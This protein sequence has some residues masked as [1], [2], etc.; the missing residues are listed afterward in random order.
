MTILGKY[1]E[2]KSI[3]KASVSRITGITTS[4]LSRLSNDSTSKLTAK[5]LYLLSQALEV[6][7]ENLL[8]KLY[9]NTKLQNL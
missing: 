3:N 6:K 5:E 4:R 8:I 1:L 9:P 7:P 2:K